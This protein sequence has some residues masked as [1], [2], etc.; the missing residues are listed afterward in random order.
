MEENM[1][2]ELLGH[3]WDVQKHEEFLTNWYSALLNPEL[4]LGEG[5][6][7]PRDLV[8]AGIEF[9]AK[10]L[11]VSL[12]I[13]WIVIY[14]AE[15]GSSAH[16]VKVLASAVLGI[17]FLLV[18]T[19]AMHV[20]FWLPG[21]E[22]KIGGTFLTYIYAMAAYSPIFP[23]CTWIMVA[24]MP[25]PLRSYAFNPGTARNAGRLA[26]QD[27]QTDKF[28]FFAGG[29][30]ATTLLFWTFFVT[31]R[32]LGF[33]HG[34]HGWSFFVAIVL[35]LLLLTGLGRLNNT[36]V[37]IMFG[38]PADA[39]R[40]DSGSGAGTTARGLTQVAGALAAG[41]QDASEEETGD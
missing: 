15:R 10:I 18:A 40:D 27:P 2:E 37:R 25:A 4:F 9:Y 33:V 13:S 1:L 21:G 3:L 41:R 20:A 6:D 29:F 17:V 14:F 12:L 22:S 31:F 28:A 19:M 26:M 24:G 30:L 39:V 8:F 32:C 5:F 36:M 35:S 34:L 7:P 16:K 23:I 11:V 38:D